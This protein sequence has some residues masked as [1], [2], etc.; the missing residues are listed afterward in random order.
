M[1]EYTASTE[2]M[3]R[4]IGD[5]VYASCDG[6]HIILDL[7]A[8]DSTT[9]IA[10]EPSVLRELFRYRDDLRAKA[11]R[12]AREGSAS[13]SGEPVIAAVAALRARVADLENDNIASYEKFQLEAAKAIAAE[14]QLDAALAKD[15]GEA[16]G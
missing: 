1:A 16:D 6:Y 12:E 4:Y 5:G 7:R 10:L 9:R 14:A 13:K 3:E 8:Q 2:Y 11:H 15:R